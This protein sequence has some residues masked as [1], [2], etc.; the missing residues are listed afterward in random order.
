MI[1]EY[2]LSVG[3]TQKQFSEIFTPPIP[4]DTIK[5]WD[6]GKMDPPDWVEGLIVEKMEDIRMI[7]EIKKEIAANSPQKWEFIIT[8][9]DKKCIE[10]IIHSFAK[11]DKHD[12]FEEFDIEKEGD[13]L[14][15]REECLEILMRKSSKEMWK[16]FPKEQV[17]SLLESMSGM[18]AISVVLADGT[19]Y[20]AEEIKNTWNAV[21]NMED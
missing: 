1:K 17:N 3:L 9:L 19:S 4:L 5:K 18:E 6:S 21:N 12:V 7:E 10:E 13:K 14:E 11:A 16:S 15:P 8:K 20:T 2:R